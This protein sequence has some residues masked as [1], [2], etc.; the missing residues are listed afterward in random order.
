MLFLVQVRELLSLIILN[1]VPPFLTRQFFGEQDFLQ[2]VQNFL[3]GLLLKV[4]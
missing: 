1:T 4:L 2:E 3:I